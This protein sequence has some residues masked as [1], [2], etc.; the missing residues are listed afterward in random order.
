MLVVFYRGRVR[1]VQ[2]QTIG[3]L[4]AFLDAASFKAD[5]DSPVNSEQ[6]KR[7]YVPTERSSNQN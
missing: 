4:V 3:L 7:G 5:T 6:G 2:G 1:E